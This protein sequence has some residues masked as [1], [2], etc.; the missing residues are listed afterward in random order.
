MAVLTRK[1][2]IR[3]YPDLRLHPIQHFDSTHY[4]PSPDENVFSN[5]AATLPDQESALLFHTTN[6]AS[7]EG[8]GASPGG[9]G[10]GDNHWHCKIWCYEGKWKMQVSADRFSFCLYQDKQQ[11]GGRGCSSSPER[12]YC[13]GRDLHRHE[14]V[15][16]GSHLW[17]QEAQAGI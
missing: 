8:R 16:R 12:N 13:Q 15:W 3:G 17:G 11:Q 2:C 6:I 7:R 1:G 9:H 14:S 5:R 4:G 10:T